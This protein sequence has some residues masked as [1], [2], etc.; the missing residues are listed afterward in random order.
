MID[1]E[2]LFAQLVK[3]NLRTYDNIWKIVNDQR[4][5]IQLVVLLDYPCFKNY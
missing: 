2:N 4:E 1:G 5:I 3:D